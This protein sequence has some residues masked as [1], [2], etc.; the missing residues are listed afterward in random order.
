MPSPSAYYYYFYYYYYYY[1]YSAPFCPFALLLP[2]ITIIIMFYYYYSLFSTSFRFTPICLYPFTPITILYFYPFYFVVVLVTLVTTFS[3]IAFA[4]VTPFTVAVVVTT[5]FCSYNCTSADMN[6]DQK[7][8][9]PCTASQYIFS[10]FW[11]AIS[12]H[13]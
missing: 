12:R 4:F 3:T 2:P 5:P 13:L 9:N 1:F 7:L 6:A 10:N 11:S 8:E